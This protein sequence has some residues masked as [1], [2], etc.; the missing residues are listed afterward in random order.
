MGAVSTFFFGCLRFFCLGVTL[1]SRFSSIPIRGYSTE[2]K[3]ME[4]KRRASRANETLTHSITPMHLILSDEVVRQANT[5]P[6]KTISFSSPTSGPP[7]Q[8][9]APSSPGINP[10][11]TD[12]LWKLVESDAVLGIKLDFLSHTEQ[13][14]G[15]LPP[16]RYSHAAVVWNGKL[17]VCTRSSA[18]V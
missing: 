2:T 7:T 12:S 15:T 18:V 1:K 6:K 14:T 8:P 11:Y 5:E 10:R 17:I 9:S 13:L 16:P 4:Q 3:K